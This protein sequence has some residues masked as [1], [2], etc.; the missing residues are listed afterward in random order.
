MKLMVRGAGQSLLGWR[1]G[2]RK[3]EGRAWNGLQA[4]GLVS[5]LRWGEVG[6]IQTD[7]TSC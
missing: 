2:C 6:I 1:H 3:E 4:V 7:I 5:E